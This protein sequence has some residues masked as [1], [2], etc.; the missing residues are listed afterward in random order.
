VLVAS[1]AQA[2]AADQPVMNGAE[3]T[4]YL[5]LTDAIPQRD[6]TQQRLAPIP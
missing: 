3:Q 2:E 6:I 1:N 5:P 4:V